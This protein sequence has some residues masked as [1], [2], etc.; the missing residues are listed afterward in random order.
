MVRV[1]IVIPALDYCNGIT[2]YAMNYYRKL[3]KTKIK[4]DFAVHYNL[5]SNYKQEIEADGNNV[6]YM[7]NYSIQSMLGLKRRLKKIFM[8]NKYDII[9]CHILNVAYFYFSVARK[10]NI[11]VR[12]LHSHATKNSDSFLKN[13]RNI[14]FKK[15]AL[16]YTTDRFACS[17][18]AGDY[19]FKRDYEVITNAIDYKKFAYSLE[20][21]NYLR[22]KYQ[23]KESTIVF[24]LI[25]R[26]TPQKNIFFALE[27]AKKLID[28][29]NICFFICGDGKQKRDILKFV[30]NN[31][32][33]NVILVDSNPDIY[34]YYSLFNC[35]LLPSLFEGLPVTGVEAQVAGCDVFCSNTITKELNFSGNCKY[36]SIDNVEFWVDEILKYKPHRNLCINDSFNIDIQAQKLENKYLTMIDKE[37]F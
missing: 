5:E 33:K 17:K 15:M 25:G 20:N 37:G 9:H 36:L 4:M 35:L 23:L 18:L 27:I 11:A 31:N 21:S 14:F 1:L 19:L 6:Y 7:G 30:T 13:I 26:F 29:D 12:I 10:C 2:S 28:V 8:D 32:L 3:D 16:K 22:D 34:K 24:G